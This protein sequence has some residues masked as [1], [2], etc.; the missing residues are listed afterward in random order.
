MW[1]YFCV[2]ECMFEGNNVT[3]GIWHTLA[4]CE[5]IE[6]GIAHFKVSYTDHLR[7]EKM[8]SYTASLQRRALILR[9]ILRQDCC[10]LGAFPFRQTL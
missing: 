1:K 9:Q 10:P 2:N 3:P 6:A 8:K 4:A 5:I 7:S